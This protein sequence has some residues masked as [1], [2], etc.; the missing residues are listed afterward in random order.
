VQA[1]GH[2]ALLRTSATTNAS[3][4]ACAAGATAIA[5]VDKAVAAA[6]TC[7]C[8]SA[9]ISPTTK[10]LGVIGL[11][12]AATQDSLMTCCNM[13]KLL[14]ACHLQFAHLVRLLSGNSN[15]S[16]WSTSRQPRGSEAVTGRALQARP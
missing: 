5:N 7:T 3:C 15:Y 8:N 13:L 1:T 9:E 10:D 14:D 4:A 12:P 2:T 11:T 16:L 6:A